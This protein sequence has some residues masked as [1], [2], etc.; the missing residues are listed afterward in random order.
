M[1]VYIVLKYDENDGDYRYF[2]DG[3]YVVKV[4]YTLNKAQKFITPFNCKWL[5]EFNPFEWGYVS[6]YSVFSSEGINLLKQQYGNYFDEGD[7]G[8][9]DLWE[10]GLIDDQELEQLLPHLEIRPPYTILTKEIE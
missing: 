8:F 10:N 1:L 5:R 9:I 4:F 2:D 7:N 3:T 6:V